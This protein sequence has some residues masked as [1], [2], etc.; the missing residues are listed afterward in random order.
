M[1]LSNLRTLVFC[2]YTWISYIHS[3]LYHTIYH[4]LHDSFI[5]DLRYLTWYCYRII[6]EVGMGHVNM[7]HSLHPIYGSEYDG[8]D[9]RWPP[10]PFHM[11][12]IISSTLLRYSPWC[13]TI[14]C[15]CRS[16][17]SKI[18]ATLMQHIQ[19]IQDYW[20]N[21]HLLQWSYNLN[22]CAY[23]HDSMT[24]TSHPNVTC[25]II[26]SHRRVV[27]HPSCVAANYAN[28]PYW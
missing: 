11:H 14:R 20:V 23:F 5:I 28:L 15:W 12:T 22:A 2:L 8:C 1:L 13:H 26:I 25:T 17:V 18:R 10:L 16:C 6:E 24:Q 7:I 9:R 21:N 4:S 3:L 19:S 27:L